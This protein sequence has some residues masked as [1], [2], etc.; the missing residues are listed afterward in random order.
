MGYIHIL[1]STMSK[2]IYAHFKKKCS[3]NLT[4]KLKCALCSDF[5]NLT[6]LCQRFE[7]PMQQMPNY[8]QQHSGE[9]LS[10]WEDRIYQYRFPTVI[11]ALSDLKLTYSEQ[12][13]PPLS[14]NIIQVVRE[15]PDRLRTEKRLFEKIGDSLEPRIAYANKGTNA[16]PGKILKHPDVVKF[17]STELLRQDSKSIF[18]EGFLDTLIQN[19]KT[20]T[21]EK[22]VLSKK[23][24]IVALLKRS[25]PKFLKNMIL[26][27]TPLTIDYNALAFRVYI[28]IFMHRLLSEESKH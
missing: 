8:L 18:P 24:R 22:Q 5:S 17:L 14:N 16:R 12:S 25:T 20:D 15:L 13:T 28:I 26:S 2:V 23:Q 1:L 7:L 3:E 4:E 10:T 21:R 19:L 6:E 27:N 9:S 11:A